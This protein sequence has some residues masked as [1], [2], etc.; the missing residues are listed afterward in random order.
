MP[1]N[2]MLCSRRICSTLFGMAL[3]T[4]LGC[5]MG[6]AHADVPGT[7]P[8][9]AAGDGHLWWI[10]ERAPSAASGDASSAATPFLL[11]HH[12]SIEPAP[13]E[14]LVT[15]LVAEPEALAAEGDRLIVITR[16]EGGRKR[17]VF[18]MSAKQNPVVGHWFT[19][20]RS[21][22]V[23]L[24]PLDP[25][26][27]LRDVALASGTLF[28]LIRSPQ[29]DLPESER[30]WLGAIETR[31]GGGAAWRRVALP[32]LDL[33]E[34]LRLSSNDGAL[35]VIGSLAGNA[36]IATHIADEN[37]GGA[38]DRWSVETP[39]GEGNP[40]PSR[41]VIGAFRIEGRFAL[42]ERLPP[43]VEGGPATIRL[44]LLRRG[45]TNG[46]ASFPEPPEPWAI[47]G[48][49]A[50][51]ALLSIDE[52]RRGVVRLVPLS[53]S[54]PAAA[55]A[56]APPGFAASTWVHI[57][58]LGILSVALALAAVIFGADAYLDNRPRGPGAAPPI[59]VSR[60]PGARLG[61]RGLAMT[62]DLIPGLAISW[63]IFRGDPLS[64][65]QFPIFVTD[66]VTG[67]P[68]FLAFGFG[69]IWASGGDLLFG[70]S[71]GKRIMRLEIIGARG[72]AST[73]GRRALRTLASAVT[74][75]SPPVMLIAVLNPRRDGPAEMVSGTA[76]VEEVRLPQP[77]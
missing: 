12:A 76:V 48:F 68:G 9:V 35:R 65:L 58:V 17:M 33:E 39:S 10:V 20:P 45:E 52:K 56:L 40:L 2:L 53:A 24:A 26:G 77:E 15:R 73:V 72:E 37:D 71:L 21:G 47:A 50:E 8:L 29:S 62:L 11:M 74:L 6:S 69:W 28:A 49:G 27:Q 64:Y 19:E 75:A 70:R 42:V 34:P 22:P 60:R 14:R 5:F 61:Q 3:S 7:M 18:A 54:T 23:I 16:G 38:G 51:A 25:E 43:L 13:T 55:I 46:W 30:L 36:V 32:P 31:G 4:M 63:F 1:C 41:R 44:A 67:M 57:P 66:G 59:P